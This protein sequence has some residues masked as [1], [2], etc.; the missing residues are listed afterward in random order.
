MAVAQ[1]LSRESI[2]NKH[3]PNRNKQVLEEHRRI[4]DA[5]ELQD[6]EAARLAMRFHI[7]SI[8]Q[9]IVNIQ[10]DKTETVSGSGKQ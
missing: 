8:K 10:N 3:A 6:Q 2:K 7:A 5:I 4:L 9:R 1:N